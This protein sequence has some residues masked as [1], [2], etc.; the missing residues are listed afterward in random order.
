M[1]ALKAGEQLD[2]DGLPHVGA[3]IWP[4][5][6]YY[7]TQDQGDKRYSAHKLKG[8]E[9]AQVGGALARAGGALRRRRACTAQR[10]AAAQAASAQGTQLA[11]AEVPSPATCL[12]AS[13]ACCIAA[14][15]G[16]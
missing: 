2:V 13:A 5:E 3:I 6:S 16:P 9:V 10:Q 12:H 8:E 1:P 15:A 14:A 4:G 7:S 11:Q